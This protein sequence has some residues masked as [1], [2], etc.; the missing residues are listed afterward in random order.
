MGN[1]FVKGRQGFPV[2]FVGRPCILAFIFLCPCEK[3]L[4]LVACIFLLFLQQLPFAETI[5]NE[6]S[7]S[8]TIF[9]VRSLCVSQRNVQGYVRLS[10]YWLSWFSIGVVGSGGDLV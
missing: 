9:L 10:E 3:E 2:L 7:P 6:T 8:I 4:S 1:P 5:T